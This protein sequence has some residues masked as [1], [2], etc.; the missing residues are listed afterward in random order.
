M[1]LF[2]LSPPLISN[3]VSH[4]NFFMKNVVILD[5]DGVMITT[6]SWKSDKVHSDGYSAFNENAIGNLNKL[7][8]NLDAELWLSSTRRYNKS[9]EEFNTIFH[10]RNIQKA[11]QGFLPGD[12]FASRVSEIESFLSH[13]P[14]QN[15]IILDDDQSLQGL[16]SQW[17]KCWVNTDPLIGFNHKKLAEA[18]SIIELWK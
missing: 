6:P 14:I 5:L 10:N 12:G 3:F 11:L 2:L 1:V 4:L 13:E 18:L 9:L 8:E 7:L 15:F 17:K 16:P